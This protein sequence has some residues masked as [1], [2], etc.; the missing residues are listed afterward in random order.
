[1]RVLLLQHIS[2]AELYIP[3]TENWKKNK[4][5][6]YDF[7]GEIESQLKLGERS[8]FLCMKHGIK[9]SELEFE[10]MTIIDKDEKSFNSHQTPLA[11]LVKMINQLVAIELQRKYD[12]Y[13]TEKKVE[14][15]QST[16][17]A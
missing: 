17:T 11:I 12:Y 6:L 4:G 5:F 9:L 2:K 16:T 3:Q 7:N 1:M 8:A 14:K 10:A 15:G 13:N